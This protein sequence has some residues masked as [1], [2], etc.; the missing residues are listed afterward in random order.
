MKGVMKPSPL[1]KPEAPHKTHFAQK[2]GETL[3][4][5]RKSLAHGH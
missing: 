3:K 5:Q 2:K 4:Q 1:E